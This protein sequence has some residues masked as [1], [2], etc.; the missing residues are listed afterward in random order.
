MRNTLVSFMS[1]AAISG[2]Q[3]SFAQ[4]KI[5]VPAQPD[6]TAVKRLSDLQTANVG[7]G[8]LE[9][10]MGGS[11]TIL[12]AAGR[13]TS[14][15]AIRIQQAAEDGIESSHRALL[16]AKGLRTEAERVSELHATERSLASYAP[17]GSSR[18]S[19]FPGYGGGRSGANAAAD[20]LYEL[21]GRAAELK[22]MTPVTEAERAAKVATAELDLVK[23]E[24]SLVQAAK[25]ARRGSTTTAVAALFFTIDGV[26][27]FLHPDQVSPLASWTGSGVKRI[28]GIDSSPTQ[29]RAPVARATGGR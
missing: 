29:A 2:A 13:V 24:A 3:A 21:R 16:S 7:A 12:G 17:G 14:E 27:R 22:S 23:A 19:L 6:A 1:L 5:P 26:G 15:K 10:L 25:F 8:I 11:M 4:E 28:L 9:S 18:L 20:R